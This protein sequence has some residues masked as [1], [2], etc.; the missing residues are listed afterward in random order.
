MIKFLYGMIVLPALFFNI[1]ELW[2][3]LFCVAQSLFSIVL[4]YIIHKI[5]AHGH[6]AAFAL[7]V[8]SDLACLVLIYLGARYFQN[9]EAQSEDTMR[10]L[11]DALPDTIF[12]LDRQGVFLS[13]HLPPGVKLSRSPNAYI[14]H[15]Y[16]DCISASLSPKIDSIW[17]ALI[18]TGR[19]Q[20]F[21]HD[22]VRPDGTVEHFEARLVLAGPDRVLALWRDVTAQVR[23][24][25][26]MHESER[27][28]RKIVETTQ[29]GV[30]MLDENLKTSF[31]N[32]RLSEMF[33]YPPDEII[34]KSPIDF[35]TP[36]YHAFMAERL[37]ARKKG[38][39][40][41]FDCKYLKKDGSTVW[42]L[43]S[44]SPVLDEDGVFQGSIGMYVD[45]SERKRMEAEIIANSKMSALGVMSSGI[46]HEIN[47]PLTIIHGRASQLRQLA[48]SQQPLDPRVVGLYAEK[49]ENT[50]VRIS[51]IVKAL[52]SI[53]RES[54]DDPFEVCAASS[55]LADT[56]ELC[57]ERF[58]NHGIDLKVSL[59][60]ETCE[61]KC[62][63]AEISQIVLNLLNNAYDA[64]QLLPEKWVHIEVTPRDQEV[65][66]SVTDSG[67]GIP[68]ELR[69]KIL[70]PFFTTKDVGK[71]T[72][73]G[74]SVSKGLAESHGGRLY[75][76]TTSPHTRFVLALPRG[77]KIRALKTSF[78]PT[79]VTESRA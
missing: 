13:I 71:G 75:L 64:V 27:M 79:T 21:L 78:E 58:Y 29:E 31:V 36:D 76:D 37:Q 65:E 4:C 26:A 69:D 47:N 14:H 59:S 34:G 48:S 73:L 68:M 19:P 57:K 35:V 23:S 42:M 18:T 24:E 74:L 45:I 51:N 7:R 72:G 67:S 50:A 12:I 20:T 17:Q 54:N 5:G 16:R 15:H 61:L 6:E 66:I 49:I 55:V 32:K 8:Y 38:V 40:E 77:L 39:P 28:F 52:R 30:W 1:E 62:R 9:S 10:N 22:V 53:S 70:Q 3:T 44:G 60:T 41:L 63:P 56:L 25:K 33:G 43:I 2:P 46:A 11:I